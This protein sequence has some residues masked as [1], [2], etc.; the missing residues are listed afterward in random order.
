MGKLSDSKPELERS[1][2]STP[3]SIDERVEQCANEMGRRMAKWLNENVRDTSF[4]YMNG[5]CCK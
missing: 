4:D 1:N 5:V 3:A 2:R